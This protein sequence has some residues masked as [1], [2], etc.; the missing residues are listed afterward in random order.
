VTLCLP[1]FVSPFA[2]RLYWYGRC[3]D[4]ERLIV[5][6]W[7]EVTPGWVDG[8]SPDRLGNFRALQSTHKGS[9]RQ[10]EMVA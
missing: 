7:G 6:D 5:V 8:T 1:S 2:F 9:K 10:P 4:V 3:G